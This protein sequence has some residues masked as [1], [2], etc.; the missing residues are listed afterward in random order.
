MSSAQLG[1]K[2]KHIKWFKEYRLDV[3]AHGLGF[4]WQSIVGGGAMCQEQRRVVEL[5][6]R[7]W[8]RA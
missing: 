6:P 8:I 7:C 2:L 1:I 3:K 5:H 4:R